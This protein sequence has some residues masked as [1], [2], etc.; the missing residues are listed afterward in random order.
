MYFLKIYYIPL[1]LLTAISLLEIA[2]YLAPKNR[3]EKVGAMGGT[4]I[5][6][7]AQILRE[8]GIEQGEAK[9][10]KDTT[11]RLFK[12]GMNP[13]EIAESVGYGVDIVYKW[14]ADRI[15]G[16]EYSQ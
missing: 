16:M 14:L 9:H 6:T 1:E 8:E 3:R 13:E 10:A 2:M 12:K 15:E 7:R 11:L 4:V 5:K